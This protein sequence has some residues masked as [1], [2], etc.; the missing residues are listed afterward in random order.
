MENETTE[1]RPSA[2][3]WDFP[4]AAILFV[5]LQTSAGRLFAAGWAPGLEA[6]AFLAALG[7]ALGLGLG[8]SRFGRRMV[9]ILSLGYSLFLIPWLLGLVLYGRLKWDERLLSL[10]GRLDVSLVTFLNRQPVEDPFLF[11]AFSGLLFWTLSLVA[12]YSLTRRGGYLAAILPA[13]IVLFLVQMYDPYVAG[14]AGYMAF[15]LFLC[16]ILLGRLNYLRKRSF[17]K[18]QHIKVSYD[19]VID[20]NSTML[21]SAA[22]LIFLAWMLPSPV[23]P[24]E[25][26][27]NL[28]QR[29]TRP[30]QT[31][32]DDF[33]NLIA[34]LEGAASGASYDFYGESLALGQKAATGDT[35]IFTV[36]VPAQKNVPRYYWHVRSYD[37]YENDMWGN[38][39][40]NS[41]D[42]S[43]A[44]DSLTI[45]NAAGAIKAEY[46]F[47]STQPRISHLFTPLNPIWVSRPGKLDFVR[48]S[49]SELEP[50][51]FR[52]DPAIRAGEKYLVQ[53]LDFNP[54]VKQLRQAGADYPDWV[55]RRYLQVPKNI[56]AR[57]LDLAQE[58]TWNENT[59]YDK[60]LA[61]TNYLRSEI[62]FSKEVP[63]TPAGQTGLD[64]FLFDHKQGFCNYYAT[65]EVIL[66]RAT[67]IPARMAVGF[68]QGEWDETNP[69]IW[70]ISRENAH[71]WP[72]VYFPHLGWVQFEPTAAQLPL[73]RP[74]GIE[75]G[76]DILPGAPNSEEEALIPGGQ[77]EASD[78][79]SGS[80]SGGKRRFEWWH[81]ILLALGLAAVV[82]LRILTVKR[83]R[84]GVSPIPLPIRLKAAFERFSLTPPRWLERWAYLAGLTPM[85]RTFAVVYQSLRRLGGNSSPS[86]TPAE[87]A[88]TLTGLL[89]A[90]APAIQALLSEYEQTVYSLQAG[91]ILTARHAGKRIRKEVNRAVLRNFLASVE[92][93][94]AS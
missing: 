76:S 88:A 86:W 81:I 92:R 77:P 21:A 43:P 29:I 31:T 28:W 63:Y 61:I 87:A 18:E 68:A 40:T 55:T 36:K 67:G 32:F 69:G 60:S 2:R 71:A 57:I 7:A 34:G 5:A 91:S 42:F 85:E 1:S 56:S 15:Y 47:V 48:V 79:A 59:P 39:S 12:G 74:S 26:A 35:V 82:G 90:A 44:E 33:G 9:T 53:S 20:L 41:M 73:D 51:L 14:R 50:I 17:W 38:A 58:L 25:A 94:V 78:E 93:A 22:I 52:A 62:R 66:L 4:A 37:R 16:L 70:S 46:T 54:T 27:R 3:W 6:A 64:W 72:E 65:A 23:Q 80:A 45:P 24:L 30:W 19:S 49:D 8:K 11:I 89:P 10:L 84:R 75:T 13:G 83:R